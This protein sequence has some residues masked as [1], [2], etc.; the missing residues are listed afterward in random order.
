M[1]ESEWFKI[2]GEIQIWMIDLDQELII[3]IG[4]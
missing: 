3:Q 1:Y 4:I 2:D